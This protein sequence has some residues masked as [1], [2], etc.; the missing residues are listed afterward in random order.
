MTVTFSSHDRKMTG[1]DEAT[2]TDAVLTLRRAPQIN[3]NCERQKKFEVVQGGFLFTDK[4]KLDFPN[5]LALAKIMKT[6]A[7]SLMMGC[8]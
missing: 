8:H 3:N 2:P 4:M 6:T 1:R 5:Q 7:R